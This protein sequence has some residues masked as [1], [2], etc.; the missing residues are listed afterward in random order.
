MKYLILDKKQRIHI[1]NK[2]SYVLTRIV[3]EL[4]KMGAE[5]KVAYNDEIEV[6]F[7]EGKT[8]I[9]VQ[10]ENIENFSHIM[11]R[12]M[13]LDRQIEYETRKIIVDYIE[14]YNI[15]NPSKAIKVQN[16]KAIKRTHFYDK[17]FITH[18]CVQNG[19][20][21]MNTLYRP[22]GNYSVEHSPLKYPMI[23]KQYAGENDIRVIEGKETVKKNVFLVNSPEEFQQEHLRD[24]NLSEYIIQE[25]IPSGEDFRVFVSKGKAHSGFGRKATTNFM[26]VNAGEYAKLDLEKR[27]DLKEFAQKVSSVFG[28]DFIAVDMMMKN[29]KPVLQEISFNPGFKA[30][31]TKTDGEFIN[32]AKV[33]IESL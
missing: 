6:A 24:R 23:V 16:L 22:M 11:F 5:Y 32:M 8:T 21:I 1:E 15:S 25:F 2:Y 26:T 7:I 33:I 14:Q 12:G 3:E 27:S 29:G 19:V 9:S 10:G 18:L 28:A 31:E 17:I 4:E 20:A 30:F 13:R